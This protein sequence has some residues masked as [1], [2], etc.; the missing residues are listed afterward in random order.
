MKSIRVI[1]FRLSVV[2]VAAASFPALAQMGG[3]YLEFSAGGTQARSEPLPPLTSNRSQ[4]T[5]STVSSAS[6]TLTGGWR[7]NDNFALEV[8]LSD[9]GSFSDR[10]VLT[11]RL[12]VMERDH[13]AEE[14]ISNLVDARMDADVKYDIQS[15]GVSLLG[16]WPLSRRWNLYGR[17]G[18]ASWNADSR[19]KGRLDYRGDLNQSWDLSGDLSDS[20]TNFFYGVGVFYRFTRNYAAKLEY[21]QMRVESGMFSSEPELGSFSF[22]VRYYF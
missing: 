4:V 6:Y 5:E 17:L 9:H 22:G 13:A 11:D 12:I 10:V 18:L 20:G 3:Y 7:F 1:T 14:W 8:N 21:S 19:I 2:L 16:N 15:Y